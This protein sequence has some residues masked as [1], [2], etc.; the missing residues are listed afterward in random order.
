M[1]DYI[2]INNEIIK[3]DNIKEVKLEQDEEYKGINISF[4][5]TS[6]IY[7]DYSEVKDDINSEKTVIE[8]DY[9]RLK[10]ILLNK[11]DYSKYYEEKC[12]YEDLFYKIYSICWRK[13][14]PVKRIKKIQD[15]ILEYLK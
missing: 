6:F 4:T 1:K 9:D 5:D 7:L 11:E 3:I 10:D 15:L 14:L 8:Q 2:E 12:K 13:S